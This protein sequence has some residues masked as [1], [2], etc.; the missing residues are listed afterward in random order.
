MRL[1]NP[2]RQPTRKLQSFELDLKLAR[3][4][5]IQRCAPCAA[6][7]AA[8]AAVV[9]ALA[10]IALAIALLARGLYSGTASLLLAVVVSVLVLCVVLGV[11]LVAAATLVKSVNGSAISI[12]AGIEA[13]RQS[14]NRVTYREMLLGLALSLSLTVGPTLALRLEGR[15]DPSGKESIGPTGPSGSRGATGPTGPAGSAGTT[16]PTGPAGSRGTTGP[17]GPTGPHGRAGHRGP[18]GPR[19]AV[20]PQGTTGP[21][22]PAGVAPGS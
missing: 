22:G 12:L 21:R 7:I 1:R 9:A 8:T 14:L 20:G 15:W 11:L 5:R 16:G 6:Q 3:P 10:L 17:A 2:T 13:I 4:R 18:P 19:G